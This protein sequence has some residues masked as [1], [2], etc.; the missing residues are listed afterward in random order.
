MFAKSEGDGKDPLY[1]EEVVNGGYIC[2]ADGSRKGHGGDI[3]ER[4]W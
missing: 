1:V 2:I 3:E 4:L